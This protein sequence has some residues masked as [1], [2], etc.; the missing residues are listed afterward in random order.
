MPWFGAAAGAIGSAAGAA[1]SAIG[2]GL[3]SA[4]S[5]IGSAAGAAGSAIGS[6]AGS[7]GSALGSAGSAIGSGVANAGYGL[8]NLA[9]GAVDAIAG[10]GVHAAGG[11]ALSSLPSAP[12][13]GLSAGPSQGGL[14]SSSML[15]PNPAPVLGPTPVANSISGLAPS[16]TSAPIAPA[17][18]N[19]FGLSASQAPT[20]GQR[21][22]G[23]NM[24]G[25]GIDETIAMVDPRV[26]SPQ[27]NEARMGVL[28]NMAGDQLKSGIKDQMN[29]APPPAMPQRQAPQQQQVNNVNPYTVNS[30]N[31]FNRRINPLGGGF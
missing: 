1:G 31:R 25:Q 30:L 2:S 29:F 16:G 10:G 4:G 5:A 13:A 6:A 24:I 20:W 3:A 21:T 23:N 26:S 15:A 9:G 17:I 11:G 22:F 14:L 7:V 12:A 19:P 27:L 18:H 28:K 8:G